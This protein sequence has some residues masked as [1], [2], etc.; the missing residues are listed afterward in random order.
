MTN[1]SKY[2]LIHLFIIFNILDLLF[3]FIIHLFNILNLPFSFIQ[4]FQGVYLLFK[5]QYSQFSHR[6]YFIFKHF[7]LMY[8]N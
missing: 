7:N 6:Y 3:S 2:H 8:F 1:H 4:M 5:L